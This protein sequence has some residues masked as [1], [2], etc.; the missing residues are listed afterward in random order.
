MRLAEYVDHEVGKMINVVIQNAK[1]VSFTCDEVT[2]MD[3]GSWANV[4]GYVL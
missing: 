3:N 2:S 4:Y 1:F